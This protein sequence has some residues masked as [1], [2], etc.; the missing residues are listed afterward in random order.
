MLTFPPSS[1]LDQL[2]GLPAVTRARGLISGLIRQMSIE[3]VKGGRLQP[4]PRLLHR[5]D[6]SPAWGRARFVGC[7]VDDYLTHGNAVHLVT[8]RHASTGLPASA[9][10]IPAVE[11]GVTDERR[12]GGKLRYWW[13]GVELPIDDVVHVARGADPRMPVR[14]MGVIE[15]HLTTWQRLTKQANAESDSYDHSGVPSVAVITPNADLSPAEAEA[16]KASW[17][18]KFQRREPVI[19]PT[20]TEVK[21]LAWSPVDSQMVEAREMS[22]KDVA[23]AFGMDGAWLGASTKGLTYKSIGPLFLGLVR[24]TIEP[25][26]DD[27]EQIWGESWLPWGT[28]LQFTKSDI[29]TDDLPTEMSWIG[30]A[31]DRKIITP[32]EGRTRL[33]YSKMEENNV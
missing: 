14:G 6:P 25:V 11:L 16:A 28:E 27:F 33:G 10:W 18:E 13:G 4:R 5:P 23:N 12:Y 30:D 32:E 20:G 26:S 15:Q 3:A 7:H 1:P 2:A 29:L 17:M 9:M 8:S 24:E 19:L 22:L 31:V 21:P